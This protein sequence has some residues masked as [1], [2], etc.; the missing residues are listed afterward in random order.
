MIDLKNRA[1]AAKLPPMDD[2]ISENTA[3][4]LA[5][6]TTTTPPPPDGESDFGQELI[7]SRSR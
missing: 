3:V 7:G 2:D 5:G 6:P 1:T 4:R